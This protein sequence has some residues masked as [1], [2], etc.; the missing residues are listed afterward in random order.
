MITVPQDQVQVGDIADHVSRELDPRVVTR[1][2]GD[3]VWIW[4]LT[5]DCGPLPIENY[6]Y[7]RE[8]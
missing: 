5:G 7:S 2:E 6:T 1:V 8:G 4:I 3:Q